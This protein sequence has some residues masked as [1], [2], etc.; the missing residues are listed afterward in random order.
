[1]KGKLIAIGIL[2][3]LVAAGGALVWFQPGSNGE[4]TAS[5]IFGNV[6]IR[7]VQLAFRADGRLQSMA[8]EE[9]DTVSTGSVLAQIDPRPLQEALAV[10]QANVA[11]AQAELDRVRA[12]T[13]PQEIQQ[14]R[15]LVREAESAYNN[16][17]KTADR[18][19]RLLKSSSTSQ[20][21]VDNAR[22]ARD[23]AAAHLASAREALA[24]GEA[25]ARVEDIAAAEASLLAA[26]AQVTQAQTRVED[27][28]LVAPANGI[29]LTRAREPG[30]LLTAG[31][32]VY[33][34]T[35]ND[36]IYVRAYIE[37]QHLGKVVPGTEVTISTDSSSRRYRGRVGF[38]SPSAE[39]T[40]KTV[41]TPALRTDLVYRLRV[42][43][44]DADDELR[45]GMPVTIQLPLPEDPKS[46]T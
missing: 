3:L 39:F 44:L 8:V 43:V 12:G 7:E 25:G 41:E 18:Q 2:F 36:K 4:K 16:A 17:A 13:R 28:T 19:S 14:A 22:A 26:K 6:D 45:Q 30:S 46:G 21:A 29:I 35:L 37:E 9:G 32:P 24:L 27:A 23:Q 11:R 40:P 20:T 38:V 33:A 1:M 15:A 5:T 10:V 34:L 31:Q 42:I